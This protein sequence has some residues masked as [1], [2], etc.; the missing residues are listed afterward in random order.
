M[1]RLILLEDQQILEGKTYPMSNGLF[2]LDNS[3]LVALIVSLQMLIIA[4]IGPKLMANRKPFDLRPYMLVYNGLNFGTFGCGIV[5]FSYAL[6]FCRDA[7]SCEA[8]FQGL[9]E[10]AIIYSAY[11]Y[12][13][14]KVMENMSYIIMVLR[15]KSGQ[16]P[17]AQALYNNS[18]LW[19][20]FLGL[21]YHPLKMFMLAPY[22]E[23][24]RI[25]FKYAYYTLKTPTPTNKYNWMRKMLI[26][27]IIM[28]DL[29]NIF[30]MSYLYKNNCNASRI[31]MV[32]ISIVSALEALY[33]V[34]QMLTG[35]LKLSVNVPKDKTVKCN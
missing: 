33:I 27:V 30:H 22:A 9:T 4:Q 20:I 35:K 7:W 32:G 34:H 8:K 12:L 3:W 23:A 10:S 16:T 6:N 15:K 2:L 17:L 11:L 28:H 24:F 5:V 13:M 25:T 31:L 26:A 29:I 1:E 21:K 18:T 14:M 19:L